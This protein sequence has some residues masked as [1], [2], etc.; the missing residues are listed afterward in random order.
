MITVIDQISYLPKSTKDLKSQ[1]YNIAAKG[2]V[3]LIKKKLNQINTGGKSAKVVISGRVSKYGSPLEMNM[4][5][6][7]CDDDDLLQMIQQVLGISSV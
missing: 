6:T 3:D 4:Q 1:A 5:I 7:Q 2:S